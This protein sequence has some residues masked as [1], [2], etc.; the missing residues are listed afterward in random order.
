MLVTLINVLCGIYGLVLVNVPMFIALRRLNTVFIYLYDVLILMKS[1][2]LNVALSVILMAIGTLIAG[3]N[4]LNADYIGYL[5]V[6][7]NNLL[8]TLQY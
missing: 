4:D 8:T 3:A 5:F 7:F 6:I 2:Q 1:I